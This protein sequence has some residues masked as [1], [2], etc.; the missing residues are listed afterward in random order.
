MQSTYLYRSTC[1]LSAA[2]QLQLLLLTHEAKP[3]SLLERGI[4]PHNTSTTSLILERLRHKGIPRTPSTYPAGIR[5]SRGASNLITPLLQPVRPE[6]SNC[7]YLVGATSKVVISVIL[8]CKMRSPLATRS[9][10]A[11]RTLAYAPRLHHEVRCHL[12]YTLPLASILSAPLE[13][14]GRSYQY[15]LISI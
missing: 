14:S 10:P 12:R 13:T 8:V 15:L 11:G 7:Q 6:A 4:K 9:S 1:L 5:P 2:L 3:P